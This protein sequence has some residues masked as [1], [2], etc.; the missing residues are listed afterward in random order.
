MTKQLIR[1]NIKPEYSLYPMPKSGHRYINIPPRKKISYTV[2]LYQRKYRT[3]TFK[4]LKIALCY[5]FIIILKNKANIN[6]PNH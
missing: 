4:E 5:K 6:H 2:N 1:L 3:R